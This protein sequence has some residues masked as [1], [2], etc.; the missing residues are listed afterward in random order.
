MT[1]RLS[2]FSLLLVLAC[3]PSDG[4]VDET[5]TS[6]SGGDESLGMGVTS[7][8]Q[9][10]PTTPTFP[11]STDATTSTDPTT[12][13]TDPTTP[14]T[15]TAATDL[16]GTESSAT[17]T[18]TTAT[19]GDTDPV[20][21]GPG[22]LP[23]GAGCT[24][25]SGCECASGRCFLVPLL[26]GL[27]GE[28]LSDADC[29]GGGCT[30]PD[31]VHSTG[32]VCNKGEA[33]A[34]CMSD[35]V[36]NDPTH[37]QC[38]VILDIPGIITVATCSACDD[39]ADCPVDAPH[40]TPIIDLPTFSG[41]REC[42]PD[43]SLP[44]DHSC[45]FEPDPMGDPLGDAACQSGFCGTADVMGILEVGICGECNVDADCPQGQTCTDPL[46]DVEN[47]QLVGAL[48]Q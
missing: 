17:D 36:C 39:D 46:V 4:A 6:T 8:S 44:N 37:P 23:Q 24:D 40:C 16:P 3:K 38:A 33:G 9:S 13:T 42:R 10:D 31:P 41:V 32:A 15:I 11:T 48:C 35:A 1:L 2:T 7:A 12:P 5:G 20:C 27:C 26:G 30:P 34:G 43:A 22:D 45:E 14:T 19:N 47:D 21:P 25:E 18:L 28:C 29:P